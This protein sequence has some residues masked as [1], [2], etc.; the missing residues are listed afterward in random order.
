MNAQIKEKLDQLIKLYKLSP[1]LRDIIINKIK[2]YPTAE[3]IY[4][5]QGCTTY[6]YNI[7]L[8][9]IKTKG[10]CGCGR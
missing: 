6:I 10:G 9:T 8:N 1:S 7:K 5:A 2:Q 4:F 3:R